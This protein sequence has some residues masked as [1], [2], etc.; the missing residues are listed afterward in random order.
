MNVHRAI[1]ESKDPETGISIHYVNEHY[2]EGRLI[3]Q[4]K[5]AIGDCTSAEDIAAK[6]NQIEKDHFPVIIEQILSRSIGT[7]L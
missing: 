1:L 2:D 5:V 7:K 3:F 4:A 6:I